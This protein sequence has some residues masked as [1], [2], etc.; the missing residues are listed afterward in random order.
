MRVLSSAVTAPSGRDH[1]VL[2]FVYNA[3]F[4]DHAV[5]MP[6]VAPLTRFDRGEFL[7]A[8]EWRTRST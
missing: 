8:L 7:V 4:R 6:T 2:S 5:C 1:E 3:K